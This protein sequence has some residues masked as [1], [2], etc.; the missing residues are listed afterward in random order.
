MKYLSA[1]NSLQV[2]L[3]YWQSK[4]PYKSVAASQL[5][6]NQQQEG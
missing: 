4:N 1:D 5:F 6:D 2:E 3:L